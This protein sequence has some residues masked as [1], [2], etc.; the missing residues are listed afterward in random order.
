MPRKENCWEERKYLEKIAQ[1]YKLEKAVILVGFKDNVSYYL[2]NSKVFVMAS[3]AEGF[4]NSLIEAM[5]NGIPVVTTNTPGACAEIVGK[6]GWDNVCN[7]IQYCKY[8]ILTPYISGQTQMP[9]RGLIRE[10]YLLGKAML[11]V[12]EDKNIYDRYCR[13]SLKRASMFNLRKIMSK[14]DKLLGK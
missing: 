4:P 11:Q 3:S 5:A 7:S 6:K 8:G 9:G 12:L 10:E 1:R 13:G 14:W 2:K